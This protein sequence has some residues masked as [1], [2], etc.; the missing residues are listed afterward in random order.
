VKSSQDR[1]IGLAAAL[2]TPVF[3]GMTPIF[4]KQAIHAG[5][6][7]YTLAA[8]RTCFAALLLWILFGLFARKYT[9]IFPAGLFGTIIVGVV[10]GLGSLMYYN[11]LQYLDNAS[12]SQLLY[13]TYVIFA[14]LLSRVYG[15]R[16]SVMS[17]VRALLAF[18]AVYL[19]TAGLSGGGALRWIGIGLML[20]S[21]FMYALHVVLSQ[22]V[23]F[24]MP[25][26][27][28]TL[29]TLTFIGVTVLVV[30]LIVGTYASINWTPTVTAGWWYLLG[31]TAVTAL[32]RL[33]LFAGVR[34][35]GGMQAI[36]LNMAE[37]GVALLAANIWLDEKLTL[38]Q[39]VGVAILLLSVFL[40]RWD[41]DVSDQVYKP[42]PHPSHFSG[43]T[44]GASPSLFQM[45]LSAISHLMPPQL[46]GRKPSQPEPMPG[47]DFPAGFLSEDN[48]LLADNHPQKHP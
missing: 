47:F 33:T 29:Y 23:M 19:L 36:L 30:R 35:L 15:Q 24:E 32:S 28:M 27:T 38:I 13:M 26:Q 10:N 9:F 17:V 41:V 42:L 40:S 12:L 1:H 48:P 39:W 45:L 14:M 20:G 5:I 37:V 7:P 43:T 11:G 31:L 25:A 44:L 8:L 46:N 6:D 18:A 21:A 3:M 22:R 2:L 34:G 4:G 16:L